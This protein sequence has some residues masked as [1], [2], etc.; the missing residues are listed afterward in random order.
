MEGFLRWSVVTRHPV[1]PAAGSTLPSA[2]LSL[3]PAVA[4]DTLPVA[5]SLLL[6]GTPGT[7][8]TIDAVSRERQWDSSDALAL[9]LANPFLNLKIDGLRLHDYG[10]RWIANLPTV[11]QHDE[12][13]VQQLRDVN[14]SPQLEVKH[15]VQLK[16]CGFSIMAT[17]STMEATRLAAE[18]DPDAVLVVPQTDQFVDGFPDMQKRTTQMQQIQGVL[19][20]AS[21]SGALIFLGQQFESD[22]PSQWPELADAMLVCPGAQT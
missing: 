14:L 16:S 3:A 17:V 2:I 20:Q 21:W 7:R 6:P 9:F 12:V 4:V 15:L 11:D 13:F 22:D 18:I 8:E 10:L 1:N 19:K 5:V